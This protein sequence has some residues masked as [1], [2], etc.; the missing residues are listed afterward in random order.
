MCSD[1]WKANQIE[2]HN[3]MDEALVFCAIYLRKDCWDDYKVLLG[4]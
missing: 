2:D 1:E 4:E 3:K